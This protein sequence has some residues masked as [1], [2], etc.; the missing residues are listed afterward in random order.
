MGSG[1]YIQEW[2]RA[3]RYDIAAFKEGYLQSDFMY[4]IVLKSAF[5]SRT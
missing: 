3:F 1:D 4:G 2:I 5:P